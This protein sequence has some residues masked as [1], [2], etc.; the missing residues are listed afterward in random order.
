[1][2]WGLIH[3]T[4]SETWNNDMPP[5]AFEVDRSGTAMAL[6]KFP[7]PGCYMKLS[8]EPS[9]ALTFEVWSYRSQTHDHVTLQKIIGRLFYDSKNIPIRLNKKGHVTLDGIQRISR[10][11]TTSRSYFKKRWSAVIVPS[12]DGGPYGLVVL[13][14][15]YVGARKLGLDKVVE[16]PIH[17]RLVESFGLSS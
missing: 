5:I 1:M 7:L 16:H 4:L 11:F 8:R 6:T 17:T 14:S 2:D 12:P 3:S 10:E 15:I 9:D 13:F